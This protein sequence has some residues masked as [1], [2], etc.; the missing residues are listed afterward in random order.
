MFRYMFDEWFISKHK[1]TNKH[2]KWV[3]N[4]LL[5]IQELWLAAHVHVI[6]SD[7]VQ[8]RL[9]N[10]CIL[11]IWIL[12]CLHKMSFTHKVRNLFRINFTLWEYESVDT[13]IETYL[14]G[15]IRLFKKKP[16]VFLL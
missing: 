14:L 6:T 8:I 7:V 10:I 3:D 2:N 16:A 15:L 5:S 9:T 4:W 12:S 1:N 11:W 13:I